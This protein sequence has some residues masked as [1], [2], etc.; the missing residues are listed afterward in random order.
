MSPQRNLKILT[1]IGDKGM[2]RNNRSFA[3]DG[4]A[5]AMKLLE[6][7]FHQIPVNFHTSF[8][9]TNPSLGFDVIFTFGGLHVLRI[10]LEKHSKC[11]SHAAMKSGRFR[12]D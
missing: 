12:F 8:S 1:C 4:N 7:F 9:V 5:G 6:I 2:A 11:M 3:R 10:A